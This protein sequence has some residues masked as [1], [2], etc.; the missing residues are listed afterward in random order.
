MFQNIYFWSFAENVYRNGPD[1]EK[2]SNTTYLLWKAL[3]AVLFILTLDIIFLYI[4]KFL[5]STLIV[6]LSSKKCNN[7][8]Y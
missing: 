1:V 6:V 4:L 2:S 3:T 5:C 8:S 7:D